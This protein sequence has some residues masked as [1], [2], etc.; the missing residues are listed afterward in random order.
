MRPVPQLIDSGENGDCFRACVAS[1]LELDPNE[2][3][4]VGDP[5]V[6]KGRHHVAV[7]N[8]ALAQ[9]NLAIFLINE[10]THWTEVPFYIWS[11]RSPRYEGKTHA[12]VVS[13]DAARPGMDSWKV[14]WDPSPHRDE[15]GRDAFYAKPLA[16]YLFLALD[17]RVNVTE[18]EKGAGE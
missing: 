6:A 15:P 16:S 5:E 14:V 8:E 7:M 17:P 9:W 4:N 1:I 12:V 18:R 13:Y 3:P 2:L 10:H 11:I